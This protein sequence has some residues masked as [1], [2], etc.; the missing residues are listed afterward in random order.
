MANN[1]RQYYFGSMP[2]E[3]APFNAD[4]GTSLLFLSALKERRT[5]GLLPK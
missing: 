4:G 1:P 2:V 3:M 5:T